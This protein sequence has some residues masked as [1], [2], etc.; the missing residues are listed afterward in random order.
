MKITKL[1][2]V[3]FRGIKKCERPIE[4]S[5]F[6]VLIGRNNAGKSAILEALFL[7][8]DPTKDVFGDIKLYFVR[9]L[10]HSGESLTYGYWGDAKIQYTFE[11]YWDNYPLL[12]EYEIIIGKETFSRLSNFKVQSDD[13]KDL[14]LV[15]EIDDL[16]K[17]FE[18]SEKDI[19]QEK[20]KEKLEKIENTTF[21]IPS[22]LGLTKKFDDKIVSEKNKLMKQG[23][24][25]KVAKLISKCVEDNFTEVYLDTMKLRKELPDGNAFYIHIDDLGDGIKKAVRVMLLLEAVKPKIVLWD[26]FEVFAHPSLIE[27]LLKWLTEENWQVVLSTHSIDVL[28][29]LLNTEIKNR[30]DVAIIQLAKTSD[31]VLTFEKL[32]L[33]DLED[34]IMANQDPR[35]V[36]DLLALR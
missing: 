8:P 17:L 7:F 24:H 6:N 28:Y 10:L 11:Y 14:E 30:E 19:I 4:F 31:D 3:E 29:A 36:V 1:D 15:V 34:L 33:D 2:I 13:K 5:K 18:K 26:D 21:L 16:A 25:V 23:S 20:I 27:T 9:N 32:T 22:N 12:C 35:K